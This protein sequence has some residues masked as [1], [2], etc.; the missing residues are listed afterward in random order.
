M[1]NFAAMKAILVLLLVSLAAASSLA[2]GGDVL[3]G[4]ATV[5][6]H[7]SSSDEPVALLLAGSLLIGLA[8]ALRRFAL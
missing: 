6:L 8:G 4:M 5:A 2:Y 7:T 3:A 1:G